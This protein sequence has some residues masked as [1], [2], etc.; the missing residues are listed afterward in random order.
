[1]K[2]TPGQWEADEGKEVFLGDQINMLKEDID[3]EAEWISIG[4]TDKDGFSEIVALAHPTN[5]RLIA[6]APELYD[7][8]HNLISVCLTYGVNPYH[9]A[10]VHAYNA[11]L[12]AD[13][14]DKLSHTIREG[15]QTSVGETNITTAAKAEGRE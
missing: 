11:I 15:G 4:I 1:M 13:G 5:A 8:A 12:K 2:Y 6:A 7:A 3:T 9:P 10:I 14:K